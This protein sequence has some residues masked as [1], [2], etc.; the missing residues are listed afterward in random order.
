M[1]DQITV[2]YVTALFLIGLGY[3]AGYLVGRVDIIYSALRLLGKA[4]QSG[5]RE[6]DHSAQVVGKPVTSKLR[7]ARPTE[8]VGF[9]VKPS[10]SLDINTSTFVTPISTAG[11]ERAGAGELGKT[12]AVQDDIGSSVSKLAQLKGK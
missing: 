5:N 6:H 10:V 7:A 12:T 1:F 3:V 9:V 2:A 4:V 11:M 8:D